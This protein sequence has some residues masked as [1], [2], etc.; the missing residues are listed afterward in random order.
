MG[1]ENLK[2][3]AWLRPDGQ[4]MQ[5]DD[6]NDARNRVLGMLIHGQSA[7]EVDERGRPQ[8]GDTLLLLL[9]G[10]HTSR[11]FHLPRISSA[12]WREL[13]NTAHPALRDVRSPGVNLVAHSLI[14]LACGGRT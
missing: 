1:D 6:W 10:G 13:V 9:N 7:D 4:E 11:Y 3:V 8:H 2:D 5:P 14:L 12:P